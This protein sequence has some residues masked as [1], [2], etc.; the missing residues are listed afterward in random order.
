M[1]DQ[2][3][4]AKSPLIPAIVQDA[5]TQRVLML[6]FM[7]E[8]AVAR[9]LETRQVTFFSRRRQA[10]W[11]KGETSGNTLALESIRTDCDRD[12]LLIEATPAGP[13]CHLGTTSCF[14]GDATPGTTSPSGTTTT[15]AFLSDL[16]NTIDQ[17]LAH[18]GKESY[19]A[20]LAGKGPLKVAQKVGEEGVEVALAA[21]AEN[22]EALL[23]EAADLVFHLQVL[24][25]TRELS[26]DDVARTLAARAH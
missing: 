2:L 24:L 26:L 6:G 15:R 22:R 4:F 20:R 25:R 5:N 12:T 21:V 23:N 10:L 14:D 18:G 7:N 13:T 3:D 11:T 19:V 9:T 1:I 16:E 8:D 17:R